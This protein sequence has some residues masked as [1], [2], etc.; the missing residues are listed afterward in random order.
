MVFRTEHVLCVQRV[1][2]IADGIIGGRRLALG[3]LWQQ[4]VRVVP[5]EKKRF[6]EVKGKVLKFIPIALVALIPHQQ[7]IKLP[8]V[9]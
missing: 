2:Q 6:F 1:R 7:V 9:A 5:Q 8:H 3:F 4:E